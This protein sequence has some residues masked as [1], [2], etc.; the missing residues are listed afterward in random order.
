MEETPPSLLALTPYLLSR[1]GKTARGR[2]IERLSARELRLW[3]MAVL[4]ALADFGPQAQRDLAAR[5]RIDPSDVVKVL[6]EL[7][8]A[9]HVERARD[10]ADRRRATV[11]LT[12]A[13]RTALADLIAETTAVREE[14]LAPLDEDERAVLHALLRRLFAHLHE[15]D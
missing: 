3:H 13:G 8:A 9:G 14:V 11:T 7:A 4:A 15:G 10:P 1:V 12:A 5:L 2:I 6:D